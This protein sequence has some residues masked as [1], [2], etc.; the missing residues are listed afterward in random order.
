MTVSAFV[1][2]ATSSCPVCDGW[3][4]EGRVTTTDDGVQR[5]EVSWACGRRVTISAEGDE[6]IVADCRRMKVATALQ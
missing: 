6:S 3:E 2:L 1:A 4:G 5:F